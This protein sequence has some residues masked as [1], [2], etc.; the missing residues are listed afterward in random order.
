MEIFQDCLAEYLS[1]FLCKNVSSSQ[2][3]YFLVITLLIQAFCFLI[4]FVFN[5]ISFTPLF[6][7]DQKSWSF[8]INVNVKQ[9][10]QKRVSNVFYSFRTEMSEF[11]DSAHTHTLAAAAIVKWRNLSLVVLR[12]LGVLFNL[13]S[14]GIQYTTF[15]SGS[16][17]PEPNFTHM[18][19]KKFLLL[20]ARNWMLIGESGSGKWSGSDR[21]TSRP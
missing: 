8:F 11:C 9:R 13:F 2:K 15:W 12:K 17:Y 16:S 18:W 4:V 10:D 6:F 3:H 19:M 5:N 1:L 14:E 21:I 20:V 7:N